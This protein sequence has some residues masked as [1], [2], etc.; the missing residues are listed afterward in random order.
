MTTHKTLRTLLLC[1]L[2]AFVLL[3]FLSPDSYLRDS[4]CHYDSS[5]FFMCG[6]AWMSGM[7]PYV[8]FAD[9]K[10]PLLWLI[11]G[12]G[13]LISHHSYV[14]VFWIS[15]LFYA[16]TL[17]IAY[18]LC[19]LFLD[20]GPSALC[21]ALL[22]LALFY[23]EFHVE[24]RAEDFCYSSVLFCLYSL[25][26]V[27]RE[28]AMPRK[29]YL[30]LCI[31]MGL[32]FMFCL[33]TKWNIAA[34]IGGP[35]LCVFILSFKRK[36]VGI[37]LGGMIGGA[38]VLALP[39]V[40]YFLAFADFGTMVDE[41]FVNTY[42]TMDGRTNAFEMLTFGRLMLV[43]EKLTIVLFIGLLLFCRKRWCYAWLIF[44]FFIFRI[45]MG[46]AFYSW[47][48]YANLMPFFLFFLIAV[49]GYL[50]KK[51][52]LLLNRLTP[53]LCILAVIGVIAC[54]IRSINEQYRNAETQREAFYAA[55]YVMAQVE[56]P[57]VIWYYSEVGTGVPAGALPGCRYWTKQVGATE[58]MFAER[59]KALQAKQAD[60]IIVQSYV[61]N[62]EIG[63]DVCHEIESL[64]YEL[65]PYVPYTSR[66]TTRLY[67]PPGLKLP[68]ED[69]H[70]SQ[71]DVWLKR[72][73]F[74]I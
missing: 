31:G 7:I 67:G 71:W 33:L 65:Y 73:I 26:R 40:I 38:V 53:A 46:L 56:K 24:L 57:K 15:L 19:R 28:E 52:P 3:F 13:Y 35:M 74:G 16:A 70:V 5:C 45:G 44:C 68:P 36:A 66:S 55:N 10:G 11:Y 69:F 21:V 32:A 47:H 8:D 61:L 29:T 42:L 6:K 58:E 41:Y 9:S 51:W 72:N 48:Y 12:I 34:M 54:D 64:G 23:Y 4:F 18:K 30:Q 14:G 20:A 62:S 39:F 17:Y 59:E 1:A 60:F 2:Y 49:I 22:P 25:C 37:C 50:Y 63:E 27:I 43:R